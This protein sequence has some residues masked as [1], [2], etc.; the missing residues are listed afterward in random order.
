MDK[1]LWLKKGISNL[2]DSET[3]IDHCHAAL[4]ERPMSRKE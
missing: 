2:R 1:I 4:P 3:Q